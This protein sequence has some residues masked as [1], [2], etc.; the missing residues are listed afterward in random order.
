ML[1]SKIDYNKLFDSFD[2]MLMSGKYGSMIEMFLGGKDALEGLREPFVKKTG[3][4]VTQ[5]IS[6]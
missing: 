1:A 2:E 5:L 6:G 4:K 3:C